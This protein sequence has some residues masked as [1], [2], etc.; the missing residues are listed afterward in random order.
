MPFLYLSA[1]SI[2]CSCISG[3]RGDLNFSDGPRCRR[4]RSRSRR[5]SFSQRALGCSIWPAYRCLSHPAPQT[6]RR[7]SQEHPSLLAPAR[8]PLQMWDLTG[9]PGRWTCRAPVLLSWIGISADAQIGQ[10]EW[11]HFATSLCLG[12]HIPAPFTQ[13]DHRPF[14][15]Q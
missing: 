4:R 3:R 5:L 13:Q 14:V 15:G 8:T 6:T 2:G 7:A 12:L 10:V 9:R 11:F 1:L